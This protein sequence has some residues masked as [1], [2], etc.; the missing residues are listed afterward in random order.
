MSHLPPQQYFSALC[1]S[2][3][4]NASYSM[5]LSSIQ[6]T[7]LFN[8]NPMIVIPQRI[9]NH[10]KAQKDWGKECLRDSGR[11][12]MRMRVDLRGM[13]VSDA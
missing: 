12:E 4:K 10:L 7:T 3:S 5:K 8:L 2:G 1:M 9:L 13:I 6:F 11:C